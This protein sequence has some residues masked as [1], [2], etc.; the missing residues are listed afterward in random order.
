MRYLEFRIQHYRSID[1]PIVVNI[2]DCSLLPIVGLNESGK[3]SILEAIFALHHENDGDYG[4]QHLFDIKNAWTLG[5]PASPVVTAVIMMSIPEMQ[6]TLSEIPPAARD[7]WNLELVPGLTEMRVA[8]SRNLATKQYSL[9][10]DVDESAE[11]QDRAVRSALQALPPIHYFPNERDVLLDSVRI[12]G[13]PPDGTELWVPVF[14]RLFAESGVGYELGDLSN[15][16]PRRREGVLDQV[17]DYLNNVL[18]ERASAVRFWDAETLE[19]GLGYF[20]QTVGSNQQGRL[21]IDVTELDPQRRRHYFGLTQR[22]HGFRWYLGFTL[23][24]LFHPRQ[25]SREAEGTVYLFDEP[26]SFLH[27]E[28]QRRWV[29]ELIKLS[30]RNSV[31]YSTHSQYLLDPSTVPV[32]NVHFA[33]RSKQG[34]V[35][36]RP[37]HEYK[38]GRRNQRFALQPVFDALEVQPFTLSIS[39]GPVIITEGIYD[40]YALMMFKGDRDISILPGVDAA[41]I[42]HHISYMIAWG[43]DFRALW[44]HDDEGLKQKQRATLGFGD[45]VADKHF[46]TLQTDPSIVKRRLENLFDACDL[47]AAKNQ[48]QLPTNTSFERTVQILYYDPKRDEIIAEFSGATRDHF[49]ELFQHMGM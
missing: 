36:L 35:S 48:L 31:V 27:P 16:A 17:T 25:A 46:F 28:G 6:A 49:E 4:G 37:F 41:S 1:S 32:G 21:S 3:T 5:Q 22:S 20:E 43:L 23:R 8:I 11:A 44:D 38:E 14:N 42:K 29:E 13:G 45:I 7:A 34:A 9:G 15:L 30:E 39:R 40:Y 24:T 12:A 2:E 26:V 19:L 10:L 47:D 18:N 33:E